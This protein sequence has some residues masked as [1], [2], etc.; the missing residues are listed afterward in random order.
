MSEYQKVLVII[1]QHASSHPALE[2]AMQLHFD[3]N[4]EIMLFCS[5]YDSA[6]E[7]SFVL[8]PEHFDTVKQSMLDVQSNK[9]IDLAKSHKTQHA[10]F[11][12]RV[13]WEESEYIS[14]LDMVSEYQPDLV[15]KSTHMHSRLQQWMLNS[16]SSQ[17]LKAC[18]CP[19]LFVK[20]ADLNGEG[21][22][23]AALDP[24]H[25][26]S[27]ESQLDARVLG[28][29]NALAEVLK[30]DLHAAH[31]FDPGYWDVFLESL[32][33]ADVWTDVFPANASADNT[34]VLDELAEQHRDLF[35]RACG[36]AVLDSRQHFVSGDAQQSLPE[37]AS[38][39]GAS[40]LV[41]GTTYRT[42]LLGNTA[43]R[44]LDAMEIDLLVVKPQ[45]FKSPF[46]QS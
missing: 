21:G 7:S 23:I 38:E 45:G 12:T 24:T 35:E 30:T 25:K 31:C 36:S 4:T 44:L 18:P 11:A 46:D 20:N 13:V 34:H 2:R 40:V 42:G 33:S 43:E 39:L 1:D 16:S 3:D 37:L 10:H 9:L 14:D 29:A 22:V 27:R 28:E 26:L 32:R 5:I 15:I 17:L 19:V 8:D 41:I 6:L